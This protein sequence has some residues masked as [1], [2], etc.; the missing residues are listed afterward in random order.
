M[1][2]RMVGLHFISGQILVVTK[3]RKGETESN[4]EPIVAKIVEGFVVVVVV[5][6]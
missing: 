6:L 3:R 5:F 2:G 4:A 1:M